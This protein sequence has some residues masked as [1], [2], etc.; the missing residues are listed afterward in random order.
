RVKAGV[1]SGDFFATLGAVPML[2]RVFAESDGLPN[3][4]NIVILS[5]GLWQR[6]YGG[7]AMLGNSIALNNQPYQ[8]VGV[9]PSGFGFPSESDLWIPMSIPNT[10]A[11]FSAFRGFLPTSTVAR[12]APGV[13]AGAASTRL[14][15]LWDRRA[16]QETA[17]PGQPRYLSEQVQRLKSTGALMTLQRDLT[18]DRRTALVVL[19]GATVLLLLVTCANVTNLLLSQGPARAPGL[20]IALPAV[21][22][23]PRGRIVRELLPESVMLAATG[24][25][26]GVALAPAIL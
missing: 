24:T 8:V 16:S 10:F 3:G 26:I 5:Y 19:L 18:G 25:L 12:L 11:T 6:Q 7:S 21:L 13:G 23:P 1:V 20:G 2:G 17:P 14:M 9:M 22:G 15:A 4:P